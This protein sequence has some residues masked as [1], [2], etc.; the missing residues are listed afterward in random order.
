MKGQLY[1]SDILTTLSLQQQRQYSLTNEEQ[2][3]KTAV[4]YRHRV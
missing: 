4:K 3:Y 1:P 2:K